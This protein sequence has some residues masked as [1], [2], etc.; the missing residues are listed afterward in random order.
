[1]RRFPLHALGCTLGASLIWWFTHGTVA[2]LSIEATRLLHRLVGRPAPYLIVE[3]LD[4]FWL[5]PPMQLFVGLVLASSWLT[6]KRRVRELLI[7]GA[8]LW[9]V[10]V[11]HIIAIASPYLGAGQGRYLIAVC[12]AKGHLIA[13]PI[14]FWLILVPLPTRSI[15]EGSRSSATPKSRA[16]PI[17]LNGR[18]GWR[19]PVIAGMLC[20]VVPMALCLFAA[21]DPP[22]VRIARRRLA[23]SLRDGDL[24]RI[25]LSAARLGKIQERASKRHDQNL[26]YLVGRLCQA[27]GKDRLAREMLSHPSIHPRVRSVVLRETGPPASSRAIGNDRPTTRDSA[28]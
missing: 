3:T 4:F 19:R 8:M 15:P 22:S 12:L 28:P 13:L 23:A 11:M 10:V 6:W 9:F 21:A 5:A 27:A 14:I 24:D 25:T 18:A 17:R 7:G 16:E 1:M 20:L 2:P 26:Y